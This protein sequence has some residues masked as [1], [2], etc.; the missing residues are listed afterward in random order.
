MNRYEARTLAFELLFAYTYAAKEDQP[1]LYDSERSMRGF[2]ENEYVRDVVQGV[3]DNLAALDG[4]IE[5][6]ASGWKIGRFSRVTLSIL[7]L[8]VYEM[9]Y[10]TDI[11][12][13]VSI[14][15]AVELAKKYDDGKASGFINGILNTI[16]DKEGLKKS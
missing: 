9:L 8:S 6:S 14:N 1:N 5:D 16:A 12:Y 7:R 13:T 11:P 2:E 10:R 15:E 4:K 3:H